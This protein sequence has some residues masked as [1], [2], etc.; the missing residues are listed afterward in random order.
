VRFNRPLLR[1]PIRFCADTL[2][3][4][5]RALPAKAWEPHPQNFP[6]NEAAPLVTPAGQITNDFAGPMGPT[7]YLLQSPYMM[8]AMGEIGAVWGRGRLMGL[9]AG[10]EVPVHV[11]SN[12]YWR[13]H[14][15]LHIA[16]ITN[17]QV[18]FSCG[19]QTVNMAPGECWV[20]DTFSEHEVQNRGTEQRIHLVF[21]TVG[22]ERLWDLIDAAQHEDGEA[23]DAP[24]IEPGQGLNA[25]LAF[26]QLNYPKIMSPWELRCHINDM[27]DLTLDAPP[28]DAVRRRLDR[29]VAGWTAAWIRFED[30]DEGLPTYAALL[31]SVRHDL[32]AIGGQGIMMR[33]ERLLYSV[34]EK[35]V[36][37]NLI[38]SPRVQNSKAKA[39]LAEQ[40]LA[41]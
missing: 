10:A 12:Y 6:G 11:D 25:P 37:Q 9:G 39:A 38:A 13:T 32:A 31:A 26:E 20:F 15:R 4:E 21:D 1:L 14:I 5:I 30:S 22:G 28:L 36:L 34:L 24:L 17:P 35:F 23:T 3:A 2:A 29:L 41:S 18:E 33:N 16:A 8:E 7:P 27:L 19:G 40:R